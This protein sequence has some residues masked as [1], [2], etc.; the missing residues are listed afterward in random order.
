MPPGRIRGIPVR[1]PTAQQPQSTVYSSRLFV[2]AH[3]VVPIP[4]H[5]DRPA[6]AAAPLV[7]VL[8]VLVAHL[9]SALATAILPPLL[10]AGVEVSTDDALVKLGAT[11]VLHAVEGVLMSVV[12]DKTEAAG[13][14]VEAVEAHDETL[15]LAT[16][17]E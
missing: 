14:L 17:G 13:R 15:D 4:L 9:A 2:V 6:Q 1:D 8:A 10:E 16:L 12:L 7:V 5:L 3:P 11:N